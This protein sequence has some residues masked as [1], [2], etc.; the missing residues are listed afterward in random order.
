MNILP[1]NPSDISRLFDITYND[2]ERRSYRYEDIY[3]AKC[4]T[5][6]RV[7]LMTSK[8]FTGRR[9]LD[10]DCDDPP[11]DIA[12]EDS[13]SERQVKLMTGFSM[14]I[15]LFAAYKFTHRLIKYIDD[16]DDSNGSV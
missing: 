13:I 10:S 11:A 7:S 8:T 6:A 5:A 1:K 3:F 14:V 9:L 2:G 15:N 16:L 12:L 4:S